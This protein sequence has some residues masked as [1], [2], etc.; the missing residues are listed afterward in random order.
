MKVLFIPYVTN[1]FFFK[2]LEGI[3]EYISSISFDSELFWRDPC[4]FD[5]IHIHFPEAFYRSRRSKGNDPA[6]SADL[7]IRRLSEL[8]LSRVKIIWTVHNLVVHD[9]KCPDIDR[10]IYLAMIEH[11]NGIIFQSDSA[12]KQFNNAFSGAIRKKNVTIPHINYNDCYHNKVGRKEARDYLRLPQNGFIYLCL[13]KIRPYKNINAV[14]RAFKEISAKDKN[15]VLVIAGK[16]GALFRRLDRFYLKM[17][18]V[19]HKRIHYIPK[20]IEDEEIQHYLNAADVCVFA[21]KKIFMSGTVIL[22]ATFSLPV[23]TPSIGCLPDYVSEETG[24]LYDS[25][26][27]NAL[28]QKMQAAMKCDLKKMGNAF[29]ASQNHNDFRAI[30]KK[31]FDYYNLILEINT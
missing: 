3:K 24:F 10:K 27:D 30:A 28:V 6:E 20:Y 12:E 5:L 15:A 29:K 14:V 4:E 16:P 22:C 25:K 17:N 7:F 9:S 11:S 21:Y 19:L 18:A 2:L 31:T 8:H 26:D 23:I 1:P 13:G